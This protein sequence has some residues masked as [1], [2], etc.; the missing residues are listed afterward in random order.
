[1]SNVIKDKLRSLFNIRV[2]RTLPGASSKVPQE[3]AML[4]RNDVSMVVTQECPPSIWEW[5]QLMG[6]R[7]NRFRQDRRTYKKL[8]SASFARLCKLPSAEREILHRRLI[9]HVMSDKPEASRL[10]QD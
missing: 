2:K 7:E 1:M 4:I 3:G 9:Q 8:P 6:W 10:L 5:L